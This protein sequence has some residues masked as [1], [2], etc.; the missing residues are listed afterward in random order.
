MIPKMDALMNILSNFGFPVAVC[1]AMFFYIYHTTKEN[2]E[3]IAK[4]N[5]LHREETSKLKDAIN[6]NTIA[7]TRLIERIGVLY[8]AEKRD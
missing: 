8:D 6:E 4:L 1:A 7:I 5:E 2:R 3:E